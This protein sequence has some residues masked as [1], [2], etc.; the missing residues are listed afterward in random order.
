MQMQKWSMLND[1][2]KYVQNNQYAI[3]HCELEIKAP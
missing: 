1:I 2:I 3:H